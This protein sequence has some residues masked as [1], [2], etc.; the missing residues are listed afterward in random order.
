MNRGETRLN[1]TTNVTFD[2]STSDNT[3][4]A[5]HDVNHHYANTKHLHLHPLHNNRKSS[6]HTAYVTAFS[7][8]VPHT[9]HGVHN[10]YSV[11]IIQVQVTRLIHIQ[12]SV[13]KEL[14]PDLQALP[15]LKT[16]LTLK[17][18]YIISLL[19]NQFQV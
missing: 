12:T 8:A 13:N 17:Q 9:L 19:L 3:H 4:Y 14:N 1:D 11:L 18:E 16:Q 6:R 2:T 15:S 7:G 5:S 10:L